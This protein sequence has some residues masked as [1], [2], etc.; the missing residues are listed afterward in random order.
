VCPRVGRD[1]YGKILSPLAG[2]RP[3]D[4]PARSESLYRLSYPGLKNYDTYNYN[5]W[6]LMF[7][8]VYSL[9]YGVYDRGIL[10]ASRRSTYTN[11]SL[12]E[13]FLFGCGAH[14][15]WHRIYL[16]AWNLLVVM[17]Y[18]HLYLVLR[19]RTCGGSLVYAFITLCLTKHRKTSNY[20]NHF[21]SW[22]CIE[23]ACW[24][25]VLGLEGR[26]RVSEDYGART[27][28]IVI[29]RSTMSSCNSNN[30]ILQ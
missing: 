10:V 4:R 18:T 12:P 28:L 2:I 19:L 26:G 7:R 24:E 21:C 15:I 27:F 23:T 22:H 13:S 29:S 14:Q 16:H 25:K 6:W 17:M 3:P 20:S 5:C 9:E 1:G 11:I 30:Y 8:S